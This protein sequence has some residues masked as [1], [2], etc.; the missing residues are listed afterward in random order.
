MLRLVFLTA[1][2]LY[3]FG[4]ALLL[5]N[6]VDQRVLFICVAT[7]S[8]LPLILSIVYFI[9]VWW[10]RETRWNWNQIEINPKDLAQ[11]IFSKQGD[12]FLFGTATAAHQVEGGN[13]N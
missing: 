5:W 10:H 7:L 1:L 8:P 12:K 13:K 11:T 2:L 9:N 4:V 6:L 3:V